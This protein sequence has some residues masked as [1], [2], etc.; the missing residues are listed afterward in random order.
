MEHLITIEKSHRRPGENGKDFRYVFEMSLIHDSVRVGR[1]EHTIHIF[2]IYD[3]IRITGTP[4]MTTFPFT[5][6]ACEMI[7]LSRRGSTQETMKG[8]EGKEPL[9]CEVC[10]VEVRHGVRLFAPVKVVVALSLACFCLRIYEKIQ[11]FDFIWEKYRESL[12][13]CEQEIFHSRSMVP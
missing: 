4:T 7:G 9:R 13:F 1:R 5:P 12:P 10:S 6:P 11:R 2:Y 8:H 3:C